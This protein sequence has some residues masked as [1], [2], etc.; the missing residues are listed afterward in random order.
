MKTAKINAINNYNFQ[1]WQSCI[2]KKQ[3]MFLALAGVI[4]VAVLTLKQ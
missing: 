2:R 4:A 3:V 1:Q